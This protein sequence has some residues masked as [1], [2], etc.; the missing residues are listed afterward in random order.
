MT[1]V[2]LAESSDPALEVVAISSTRELSVDDTL[3]IL[4]MPGVAVERSSEG[5]GWSRMYLSVQ[6]E[7]P[8]RAD[9][10][11]ADN[12]LLILHLDGPVEV[13]RGTGTTAQKRTIGSGG[14]F[15][16]PAGRD[17]S[18]ALSGRL[19]TLHMYLD[20]SMVADAAGRHVEPA[21]EIGSTDPLL[22]QLMLALDS[23]VQLHSAASR[24]YVDSLGTAVAAQLAERHSS[25]P[26]PRAARRE[27][28]LGARE[29]GI[30]T[31]LMHERLRS[32]LSLAEL[33][34]SVGLS[35]SQ[36]ARAFKVR[37]GVPPHRYL[38]RLRL[39]RAQRLLR[40]SELTIA[41]IATTCGF[42]HQE[43]LT[44]VMRARLDTT[45]GALRR[46]LR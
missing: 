1:R 3:G 17:L 9:F 37:M 28:G 31:D 2:T 35:E 36:F 10:S 7:E 39:D 18:V 42:A 27:T 14:L 23:A 30:A 4:A 11:G 34:H 13:T 16:Q 5:L 21:E 26:S 41:E 44:Q 29:L 6:E 38:M 46:T 40:T 19:R 22:E 8:Y 12:H 15:L 45:P 32:G 43:H 20:D 25:T 33:A 24:L